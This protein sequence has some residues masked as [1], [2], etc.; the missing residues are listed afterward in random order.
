LVLGQY[1]TVHSQGVPVVI[2]ARERMLKYFLETQ[3]EDFMKPK[4]G[5]LTPRYDPAVH[6]Q[7]GTVNVSLRTFE[8]PHE[9]HVLATTQDLS[10]EF[11]FQLD[12]N[13]GDTL[14][15]GVFYLMF[16]PAREVDNVLPGWLQ[17]TISNGRR[18]SSATAYLNAQVT[19]RPNLDVLLHA[20]ATRIKSSRV[21]DIVKVFDTVE[22][23]SNAT[24]KCCSDH[25]MKCS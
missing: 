19:L 12:Y 16:R 4:P 20:H 7:T 22:F 1:S 8:W 10:H 24:S 5:S 21:S 15:I 11:P 23:A 6:S 9:P 3:N 25:Q 2:I 17:A 14:G 18:S 13:G